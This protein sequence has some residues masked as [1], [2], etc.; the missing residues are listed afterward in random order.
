MAVEFVR[1]FFEGETEKPV[2][3]ICHGPWM[4][5]EA[6][7]IKNRKLTSFNSIHTDLVNAGALWED[8]EVVVDGGLVT[9]RSP[10]DIPAF[11]DKL[12]Q[13][14]EEGPYAKPP[15]AQGYVDHYENPSY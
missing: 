1:S 3:A 10:D 4:L 8:S 6:D 11:I 15:R 7:V 14:I 5:A 2:G 9:S 12:K 13:V